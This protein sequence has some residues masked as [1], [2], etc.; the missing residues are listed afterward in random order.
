MSSPP[1]IPRDAPGPG[2]EILSFNIPHLS[3]VICH[4]PSVMPPPRGHR[5][6][7][8]GP[9]APPPRQRQRGDVD[10]LAGAPAVAVALD[11]VVERVALAR[12]PAR[13]GD[14]AA[15][16]GD[17]DLLGGL[18]ARLVVDLLVDDG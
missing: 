3:F 10:V 17:G 1:A 5:A 2:P 18:G 7:G 4:P 16:L 11:A 14:Q 6:T 9:S 15:D 12:A 13:L 8:P